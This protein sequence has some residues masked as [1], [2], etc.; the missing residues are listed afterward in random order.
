MKAASYEQVDNKQYSETQAEVS[1]DG[2]MAGIKAVS[3]LAP[4]SRNAFG[5]VKAARLMKSA[6]ELYSKRQEAFTVCKA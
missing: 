5:L 3:V 6:G 1:S 2:Q 4:F